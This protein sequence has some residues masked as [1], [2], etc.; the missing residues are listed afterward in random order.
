ML[1]G[2]TGAGGVGKTTT[3]R[4]LATRLGLP[5]VASSSRPVFERRGITEADQHA[6]SPQERWDL[7]W[8]IMEAREALE[9][10]L[11]EGVCDRTMLD[12]AAYHIIQAGAV[13]DADRF[14]NLW[15][16]TYNSLRKYTH[17]FRFPLVTF[18]G[19]DD[20][21]REQAYG[22]RFLAD[23]LMLRLTTDASLLLNKPV[24]VVPPMSVEGR[25]NLMMDVIVG[26]V[27]H[28]VVS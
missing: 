18:A 6:M 3:A 21:M 2:I 12:H 28:V 22:P 1:I 14:D 20:G 7:Q 5:F 9:R 15:E 8:E 16:R 19:Q 4:A 25:V 17:L 24:T 10:N 23:V 27:H 13:M 26:G 11:T